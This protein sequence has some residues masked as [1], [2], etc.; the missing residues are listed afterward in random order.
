MK[1]MQAKTENEW[2]RFLDLFLTRNSG[3]ATRLAVFVEEERGTQDFWIE[4]GLP[5]TAVTVEPRE[6]KTNVELLFGS[7]DKP[8]ETLMTH[9]VLDARSLKLEL[10]LTNLG[11]CLELADSEGKHT[12]LRFENF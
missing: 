11:D 8:G 5:L 10:G 6:N 2:S 1:D 3:R 12:V 4:D 7:K 9:V